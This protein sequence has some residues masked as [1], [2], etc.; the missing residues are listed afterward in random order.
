MSEQDREKVRHSW[1]KENGF[2]CRACGGSAYVEPENQHR[3]GCPKCGFATFSPSV[4][5]KELTAA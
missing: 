1:R 2:V 5:F 4:F 3:W